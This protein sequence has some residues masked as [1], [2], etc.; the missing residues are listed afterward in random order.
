[1]GESNHLLKF[2]ELTQKKLLLVGLIILMVT[3]LATG[4]YY[5]YGVVNK[6]NIDINKVKK[7]NISTISVKTGELIIKEWG[8]KMSVNN[9]ILGN[10]SYYI[11]GDKSLRFR[12]SKLDSLDLSGAGCKSIKHD[13]WG[14]DR[15]KENPSKNSMESYAFIN[16]Y[17][18][19]SVSPDADCDKVIKIDS[20]FHFMLSSMEKL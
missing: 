10:V 20:A 3:I 17:Y 12:S 14:F 11:I 15:L 4:V 18:I 5:I 1:M 9:N 2:K 16:D 7:S 6:S 8:L 13:S 19:L